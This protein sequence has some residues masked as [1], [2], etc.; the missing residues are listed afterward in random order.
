MEQS[1][2][3][4]HVVSVLERLGISY[5]VTGSTASI[6]YGEPRFTNDLD[7]VVDLPPEWVAPFCAAFPFPD[8]YVSEE[9]AREALSRRHQ[10]NI[11]HPSSGLKV[12]VIIRK[13]TPLDRLRFAR[14]RRLKPAPDYEASFASPEDIIIKKLEFYREGA[15]EKHLRDIA[16]I[17]KISGDRLDMGYIEE[18]T[19]RLGVEEIWRAVR[20]AGISGPGNEAPA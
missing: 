4:R 14:A 12:D 6:A 11:I 9:A 19:R 2:L 5:F 10:F 13:D 17:L 15:S 8:F 18:W 1:D 3:L 7:V 20:R 16:G